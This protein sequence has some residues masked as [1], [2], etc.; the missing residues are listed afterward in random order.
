L[1]G[2]SN[3]RTKFRHII[4]QLD[5]RYT[6]EVEDIITSPPQQDPYTKLRT[7]LLNRLSPSRE[8]RT[9]QLLIPEAMGDGK[10]SQFLRHLRSLDPDMPVYLLRTIWTSQQPRNIQTALAVQPD[11]ELD[12]AARCADSISALKNCPAGWRL[13]VLSE[14]TPAPGTITPV[15]RTITPAPKIVHPMQRRNNL[16]LI[17][18]PL[19]G[20]GTELYSALEQHLNSHTLSK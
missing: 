6:A 7:K 14:T 9:H 10:P 4:S 13:S 18:L 20:P 1:A 8:Q 2:I 16:L 11:V 12:A 5:H 19:W 15:P 17:P 3:E